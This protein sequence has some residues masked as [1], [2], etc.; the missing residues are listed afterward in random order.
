MVCLYISELKDGYFWNTSYSF[1][2]MFTFAKHGNGR[3]ISFSAS[4]AFDFMSWI[5]KI[6]KL[7]TVHTFVFEGCTRDPEVDMN[8]DNMSR[9]V[10]GQLEILGASQ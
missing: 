5:G 9:P 6:I 2:T 7:P 3:K 4:F 8:V 10:I 1:L